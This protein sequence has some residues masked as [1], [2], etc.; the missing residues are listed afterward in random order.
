MKAST[1]LPPVEHPKATVAMILGTST[2][3]RQPTEHQPCHEA[4]AKAC[5]DIR[6]RYEMEFQS[7]WNDTGLNE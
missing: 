5:E 2:S 7:S 3:Q 6:R 1:T 4:A